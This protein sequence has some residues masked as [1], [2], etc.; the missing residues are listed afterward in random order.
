MEQVF[1]ELRQTVEKDKT[2][3]VCKSCH[4]LG[5]TKASAICKHNQYDKMILRNKIKN[6]LLQKNC[7]DENSTEETLS[8][9]ANTLHISVHLCKTLYTEIPIME[10]IMQR[11]SNIDDFMIEQQKQRIRC[12]ECSIW[13]YNLTSN[14][15]WNGCQ[16][17][18]GCWLHHH[19]ERE[20]LWTQIASYCVMKCKICNKI[21]NHEFER[22]HFD[23]LNM[24]D[25][26]DSVSYMVNTGCSIKDILAE[27]DRCQILCI[28]C[29]ELVT[30]VERKYGFTRVKQSLT[31]QLNQGQLSQEEYQTQF[32]LCQKMYE[33]KMTTIYN[34][35]STWQSPK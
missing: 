7:L 4:E 21:K 33:E 16:V 9:I 18:E 5:H 3:K 1:A 11:P 19:A 27:I 24:F 32:Q 15:I 13:M 30:M 25:K 2:R 34:E 17:C 26:T 14:R 31:R 22:F 29:H 35:L 23:H 10:L 28:S 20:Q 6:I 8:E 12:N